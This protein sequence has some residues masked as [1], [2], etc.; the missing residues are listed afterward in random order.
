[1]KFVLWGNSYLIHCG[2]VVQEEVH[3]PDQVIQALQWDRTKENMDNYLRGFRDYE[4]SRW[5]W[6]W[7]RY[8]PSSCQ[9]LLNFLHYCRGTRAWA[10]GL[11]Y[12]KPLHLPAFTCPQIEH[13]VGRSLQFSKRK[14]SSVLV[15]IHKFFE[16]GRS[17]GLRM[18]LN[19]L[20]YI[21]MLQNRQRGCSWVG[22]WHCTGRMW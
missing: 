18:R 5:F 1:L 14:Q 6:S 3:T 10:G 11:I 9:S 2:V 8:N 15:I 19:T 13:I 7:E 20:A 4:T 12:W 21:L 22:F 16:L 17:G